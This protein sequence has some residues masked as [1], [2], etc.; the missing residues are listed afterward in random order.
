MAERLH[1]HRGLLY[2]HAQPFDFGELD[3]GATATRRGERVLRRTL[4]D[5]T[6]LVQRHPV[7]AV[8]VPVL[9]AAASSLVA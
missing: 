2:Q 7:I 4:L 1:L 8:V 3:D 5:G 6:A 9:L